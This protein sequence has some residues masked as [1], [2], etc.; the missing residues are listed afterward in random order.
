MCSS[1]EHCSCQLLA[2]RARPHKAKKFIPTKRRSR[3]LRTGLVRTKG[4]QEESTLERASARI[5]AMSRIERRNQTLRKGNARCWYCGVPLTLA[6]MH[7]DHFLAR[8]QGGSDLLANR[9]PSCQVCNLFK[10][11]GDAEFVRERLAYDRGEFDV[12]KIVRTADGTL[13][14]IT[15]AHYVKFY[16]EEQGLTL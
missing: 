16:S 12:V 3:V 14:N 9:V 13:W 10:R 11:D 4:G 7:E 2:R 8:T 5:S 15:T 6:T 1:L